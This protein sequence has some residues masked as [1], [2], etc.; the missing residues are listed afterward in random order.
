MT[1]WQNS[2]HKLNL[3]WAYFDIT[4]MTK[5]F[6]L[7]YINEHHKK[8]HMTLYYYVAL[9]ML[10]G[11]YHNYKMSLKSN[12]LFESNKLGNEGNEKSDLSYSHRRVFQV[13]Y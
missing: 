2:F 9:N 8:K 3:I 12:L 7:K 10:N 4:V 1:P 6:H 5:D 11:M 13:F